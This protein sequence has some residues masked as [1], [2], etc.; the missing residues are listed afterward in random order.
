MRFFLY[1]VAASPDPDGVQCPVPFEVDPDETFFGPCKKPIRELLRKESLGPGRDRGEAVRDTFA[2]GRG[3]DVDQDLVDILAR[4]QPGR[5]IDEYAVFGYR[6]DGSA[7]G[8]TGSYLE[9]DG[10]LARD[11]AGW[12]R[13][14]RRNGRKPPMSVRQRGNA[15]S[16]DPARRC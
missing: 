5:R 11:L 8:R 3:L 14:A 1:I 10:E 2:R 16:N 6:E 15:T 4:A 12:V 13:R 9:M 7:D